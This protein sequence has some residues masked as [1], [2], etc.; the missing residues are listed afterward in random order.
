MKF[1]FF[2][3]KTCKLLIVAILGTLLVLAGLC[4]ITW[5]INKIGGELT[6]NTKLIKRQQELTEEYARLSGELT[7]TSAQRD[8]LNGLV[9]SRADDEVVSFLSYLDTLADEMGVELQTDSLNVVE[10]QANHFNLLEMRVILNGSEN[11]VINMIKLL[12]NLPYH[13][14]LSNITFVRPDNDTAAQASFTLS[15]TVTAE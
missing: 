2:T 13:S 1:Y 6:E 9:L 12:E 4:L 3:A 7:N 10:D 11:R 15:V 5:Q 8:S 14:Y